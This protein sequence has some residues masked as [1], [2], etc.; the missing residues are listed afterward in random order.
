[1]TLF[2]LDSSVLSVKTASSSSKHSKTEDEIT[3]VLGNDDESGFYDDFAIDNI[4]S[5]KVTKQKE[6]KRKKTTVVKLK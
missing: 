4:V 3:E 1:V 5:S 2:F 6:R